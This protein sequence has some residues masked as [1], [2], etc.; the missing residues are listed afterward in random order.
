[1]HG[2]AWHMAG[3]QPDSAT[4][5]SKKALQTCGLPEDAWG[6]GTERVVAGGGS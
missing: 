1:M 2:R 5:Q 4:L 3:T 6:E